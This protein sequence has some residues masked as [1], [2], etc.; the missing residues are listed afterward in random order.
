MNKNFNTICADRNQFV[1]LTINGSDKVLFTVRFTR[2]LCLILKISS[3]VVQLY[4]CLD[5]ITPTV[6]M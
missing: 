5:A 6:D 4:I 1:L 3:K 2:R